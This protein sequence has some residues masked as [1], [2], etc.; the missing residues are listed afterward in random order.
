M[1][2]LHLIY[3]QQVAGAE[4]YLLDLLP[5]LNKK[6]IECHLIVI[7]PPDDANKF[8]GYVEEMNRIKIKTVLLV[9]KYKFISTA[10]TIH[11]YLKANNITYI[12]SHL[13]KSDLL[14]V[15]IKKLF[16]K[17]IYLIST[18]HGYE[19]KY[20]NNFHLLRGKIDYNFYYF[21]SRYL[22]KNINTHVAVSKAMADLFFKLRLTKHPIKFIHH[23]INLHH[24]DNFKQL[25][26]S[27]KTGFQIISVGRLEPVKG[28]E[29]LIKAMPE[30]LNK[31]PQVQLIILG[32]GT[33][34]ENLKKLAVVLGIEKNI[35]F[36]GFQ[37]N[38][39]L[40]IT[41]SDIILLPSLFESFGLVFIEA[42]AL[43][44]PVIAFDM[45]AGNEIIDNNETGLLIPVFDIKMLAEKMIYLLENPREREK[46]SLNAYKRF[47]EYY[48][49]GRMIDET[50]AWYRSFISN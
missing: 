38:P 39:F 14:A 31:F 45:P 37:P 27:R 2:I 46:I 18:R 24:L 23:G 8:F 26:G 22:M 25:E 3:S 10:Q 41:Q 6:G 33:E 4:K 34:K 47:V 13:F 30:V 12:H 50:A 29:F 42:F 20:L 28:H 36:M 40:L 21:L 48:N 32:N 44:T 43:K 49:A 35:S 1:K 16:N 19:E 5:G 9:C 17:K 7:S 15:L 11:R